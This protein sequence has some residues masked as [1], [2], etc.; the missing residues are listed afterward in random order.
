MFIDFVYFLVVSDLLSIP[1]E[2]SSNPTHQ[3]EHITRQISNKMILEVKSRYLT[4]SKDIGKFSE[5]ETG[6]A[7]SKCSIFTNEIF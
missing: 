4:W 7:T 3:I 6:K 2:Q 5:N 1:M